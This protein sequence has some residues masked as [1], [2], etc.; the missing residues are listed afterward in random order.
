MTVLQTCACLS[1]SKIQLY[2]YPHTAEMTSKYIPS[3]KSDDTVEYYLGTLLS[4][5]HTLSTHLLSL[6]L[7]VLFR[8]FSSVL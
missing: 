4:S 8:V 1:S 3:R 2:I 6:F 7:T 5:F